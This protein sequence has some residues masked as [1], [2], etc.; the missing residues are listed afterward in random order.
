MTLQLLDMDQ[1]CF[2]GEGKPTP[3]FE[4]IWAQLIEAQGGENANTA[5]DGFE[6]AVF[7]IESANIRARLIELSRRVDGLEAEIPLTHLA[8]IRKQISDIENSLDPVIPLQSIHHRL[9]SIEAQL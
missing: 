1:V 7:P 3:Y 9:N 2:T 4:D 6:L 5:E 8:G